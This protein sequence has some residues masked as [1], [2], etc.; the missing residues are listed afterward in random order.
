LDALKPGAD[1]SSLEIQVLG[2]NVFQYSPVSSTLKPRSDGKPF[3][4]KN[5]LEFGGERASCFRVGTNS[6]STNFYAMNLRA[7]QTILC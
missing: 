5:F 4:L 6:L 1:F 3:F 7:L 2:G